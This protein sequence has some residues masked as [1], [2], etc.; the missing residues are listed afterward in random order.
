METS[1]YL[2]V[3]SSTC[4][5]RGV[6]FSYKVAGSTPNYAKQN[7]KLHLLCQDL[8]IFLLWVISIGRVS[9]RLGLAVLE[10]KAFPLGSVPHTVY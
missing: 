8:H 4:I 2:T 10:F 7:K 3:F 5:G 6:L 9:A 1:D